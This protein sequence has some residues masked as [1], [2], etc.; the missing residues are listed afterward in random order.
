MSSFVT[1]PVT[2]VVPAT[3][4]NLGPG[5]D[6]LGLALG[7]HDRLTAEVVPAGLEIEIVGEGAGHLPRTER[8]LVVRAMRATFE[9]LGVSPSGLRL[10][11]E[12]NIPQS[13][14][15]GSSS[16]AIVGGIVLARALVVGGERF[17]D[18][19]VLFLANKLEGHPDNVAPAVIG[20]FVISG[21]S[22]DEVWALSAPISTAIS[23]IAFVPPDGVSTE[24]ARGLLPQQV[25]HGIAAANTGRAAI[26]VA[27][28]AGAPDQLF[29]GTEDFLH[30]QY[31]SS[32]MPASFALVTELRGLGK[33]AFI[34]GA[35]PTVLVLGTAADLD[36]VAEQAPAGWGVHALLVDRAGVTVQPRPV[37]SPR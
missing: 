17:D 11:F 3:S 35:G 22:A 20:G 36:G 27:A 24:A 6:C 12:N 32:A 7:L 15:L 23:A 26:L 18:D 21:Q 19:S 16:A 14:G 8:H 30:Q 34:S 10:R 31:R 1:G 2:V 29:R 5:F 37:T 4:A 13:R 25:D 9:I 28:L 33:A